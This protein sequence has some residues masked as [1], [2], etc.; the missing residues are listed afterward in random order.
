MK[1]GLIVSTMFQNDYSILKSI[2]IKSNAVIINQCERESIEKFIYN[3]NEI[4]WI[5]SKEKG[6]SKSRNLGLKYIDSDIVLLVDDDEKLLDDY[7]KNIVDSFIKTNADIVV[8]N[9][10]SLGNLKKRYFIKRIKKLKI[11]EIM[12]Y[13][14]ARMAFQYKLIK[15]NNIRFNEKFGSGAKISCGEDSIFL[16]DCINCGASI[17]S[18]PITIADIDDSKSTWFNGYNEKFLYDKGAVLNEMFPKICNFLCVRYIIK[19][20]MNLR[21]IGFFNSYKYMIKGKNR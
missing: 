12:R 14:S 1:L 16:K 17:Y 15:D 19:N 11:N 20:Y 6:L 18:Y 2:N 21:K 7:E 9:I 8:F 10:N 4:T 5:N 13:G 3:N